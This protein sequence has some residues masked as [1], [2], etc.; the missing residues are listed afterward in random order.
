MDYRARGRGQKR[1]AETKTT[2]AAKGVDRRRRKKDEKIGLEEKRKKEKKGKKRE[3]R[4][5]GKK[6]M[7]NAFRVGLQC[8]SGR[9]VTDSHP[10][11][12]DN[13]QRGARVVLQYRYSANDN[14]CTQRYPNRLNDN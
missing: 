10:C 13:Y 11:K 7:F 6:D 3:N 1:T 5:Q 12:K 2:F 14:P 9:L 8:P 4:R